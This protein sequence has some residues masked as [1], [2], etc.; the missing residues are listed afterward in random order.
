MHNVRV[1]Q[2]EATRLKAEGDASAAQLEVRL[3]GD[4]H[5]DEGE[6]QFSG[7]VCVSAR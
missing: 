7:P 2:I 5:A 6:V 3:R 1:E 4:W